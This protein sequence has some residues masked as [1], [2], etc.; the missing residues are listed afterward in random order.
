MR[1]LKFIVFF[2][3]VTVS[4]WL[5]LIFCGGIIFG[6]IHRLDVIHIE[7][8][9]FWLPWL[10]L[11][12]LGTV[13]FDALW[14]LGIRVSQ[15]ERSSRLNDLDVVEKFAELVSRLNTEENIFDE[16]MLPFEKSVILASLLRMHSSSSEDVNNVPAGLL[17]LALPSFQPD[18]GTAPIRSLAGDIASWREEHSIRDRAKLLT[19]RQK[20]KAE[21]MREV[22]IEEIC[23][24]FK[25]CRLPQVG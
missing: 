5:L 25:E 16:R 23:S 7:P 12:I 24:L 15:K 4:V 11:S 17:A 20:T 2:L 18:V 1:Q 10:L 14:I 22:E 9:L 8:D 19:N 6:I 21:Q 13:I 3:L